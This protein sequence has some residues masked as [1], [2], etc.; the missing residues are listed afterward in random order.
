MALH[1]LQRHRAIFSK[2]PGAERIVRSIDRFFHRV[3]GGKQ[4]AK[5]M[6]NPGSP[7]R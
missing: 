6:L 1:R 2:G 7:S 5:R 4:D 3:G